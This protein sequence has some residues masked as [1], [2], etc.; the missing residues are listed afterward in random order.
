MT[1]VR[2]HAHNQTND[3]VTQQRLAIVDVLWKR[4]WSSRHRTGTAKLV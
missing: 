1:D 4:T 2:V 3:I